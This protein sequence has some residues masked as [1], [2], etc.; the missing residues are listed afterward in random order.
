MKVLWICQIIILVIFLSACSIPDES[1]QIPL[2]NYATEVYDELHAP[3]TYSYFS[4]NTID[5]YIDRIGINNVVIIVSDDY[6]IHDNTTV[7]INFEVNDLQLCDDDI[8]LQYS[9]DSTNRTRD[10]SCSLKVLG[11]EILKDNF[12]S[13]TIDIYIVVT[14]TNIEGNSIIG[15]HLYAKIEGSLIIYR[16]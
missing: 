11:E 13:N 3:N 7:Y 6:E 10:F 14:Y 2:S 15:R 16:S 9:S 4:I 5:E 1:Y 8:D 12:I